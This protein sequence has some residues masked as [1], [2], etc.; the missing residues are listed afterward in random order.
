MYWYVLVSKQNPQIEAIKM[1]KD[2][3]KPYLEQKNMSENYEVGQLVT[4]VLGFLL[5]IVVTAVWKSV[6]FVF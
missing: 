1:K 2:Y 3:K 4:L 6:Q 5:G